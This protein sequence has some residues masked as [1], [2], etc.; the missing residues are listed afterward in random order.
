VMSLVSA[1]APKSVTAGSN[2]TLQVRPDGVAMVT[3]NLKDSKVNVL[4]KP[5]ME[6]FKYAGLWPLGS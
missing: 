5:L 3:L 4:S 1:V 6:D 2:V